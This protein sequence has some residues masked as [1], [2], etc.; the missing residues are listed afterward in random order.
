MK[1]ECESKGLDDFDKYLKM[2]DVQG[3]GLQYRVDVRMGIRK[4][5][6]PKVQ[7]FK[8]QFETL[9]TITSVADNLVKQDLRDNIE[10][11][12]VFDCQLITERTLEELF[13]FM[14]I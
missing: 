11:K 2:Q 13:K 9:Q 12:P 1:A 8:R 3:S 14:D 5:V 4:E 7:V 10:V 6:D